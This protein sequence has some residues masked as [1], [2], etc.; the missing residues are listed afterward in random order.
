M[1]I[2]EADI[3][4][5]LELSAKQLIHVHLADNDRYYPGHGHMDFKEIFETLD[6]IS[7]TGAV[8]VEALSK[9]DARTAGSESVRFL[10]KYVH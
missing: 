10:E 6:E 3:R 8:A 1:N 5:S 4:R 2:E 9:P 7:Y